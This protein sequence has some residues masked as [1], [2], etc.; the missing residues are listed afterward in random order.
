MVVVIY[1]I[2]AIAIKNLSL[3]Q[4]N[5]KLIAKKNI[6]WFKPTS[7]KNQLINHFLLCLALSQ[8]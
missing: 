3:K 4:N 6:I 7:Q 2:F 8:K 1:V 5:K